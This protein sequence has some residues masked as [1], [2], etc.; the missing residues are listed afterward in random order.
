[1]PVP[2]INYSPEKYV[3]YRSAIPI[4]M[5][6][7]LD[8]ESWDKAEWTS[9][10]VDIEGDLKPKP[11]HNT[12]GKMLWDDE[13]FYFGFELEEPHLWATLTERNAVIY[14]DNDI[15]IFIDPDGDTH[16]Y[17]E[18]EVNAFGTEWDLFLTKP[19]RDPGMKVI[20]EWDIKGLITK[21]GLDGTLNDP[22]DIDNKWTVEI[23]IPW[24]SLDK[25]NHP[26]D[27]DQWRVNFAR[28]QWDLNIVDGSYKKIKDAI[29][30]WGW[31]P[32]GLVNFHYPEMWGFVQFS[33]KQVGKDIA[34]FIWD[35]IEDAKWTLRQLYY[36]QR[37]FKRK[38]RS[39][40]ND[41]NDLKFEMH[42]SSGFSWP[43]KIEATTEQFIAKLYDKKSDRIVLIKEDGKVWIEKKGD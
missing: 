21:I 17:Y 27:G 7:K 3:C 38:N 40:T 41:V 5:D 19:Y 14:N 33:E 8:D 35:P 24:A 13:Y 29:Y 34:Q 36:A 32:Q 22:S 42:R 23:A 26:S 11:F 10:F 37:N 16:N 28:V 12:Q 30:N 31:S 39:F 15:E 43:P 25:R 18:L 1:M 6:G 9:L 2:M 4:I 20:N